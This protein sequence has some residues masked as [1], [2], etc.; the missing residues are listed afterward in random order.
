MNLP[1]GYKA[2]TGTEHGHPNGH[3]DLN[4][5]APGEQVTAT[6]I[7]RRRKDGTKLRDVA[8]FQAESKAP[9]ARTTRAD[10]VAKHGADPKELEAVAEFAKSQG[11][12]VV[13]SHVASRSVVVRGT[14]AA[15]DKAFA[16]ELHD[17]DSPRGKYRSHSGSANLP[18]LDSV[19]VGASHWV[20]RPRLAEVCSYPAR[21]T[22]QCGGCDA[23]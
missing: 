5:T 1:H 2:V 14:A 8:D 12:E 4:P 13:E 7:V 23:P 18:H 9:R 20:T 21:R 19:R 15:I 10:F 11:L 16:I 6:I 22:N 3:K 17:Y